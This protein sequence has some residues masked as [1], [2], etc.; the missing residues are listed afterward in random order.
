MRG[1]APLSAEDG[2][3]D[4]PINDLGNIHLGK[5]G[6]LA[7]TGKVDLEPKFENTESVKIRINKD[8]FNKALALFTKNSMK[9]M[10]KSRKRKL[11][12][13]T[14]IINNG[15]CLIEIADTGPGMED[16]VWMKLFEERIAKPDGADG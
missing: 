10:K 12:V 3:L 7:K 11:T 9:A 8:W 16:D 1:S 15:E 4:E 6:S 14:K 2:M 5:L 13:S